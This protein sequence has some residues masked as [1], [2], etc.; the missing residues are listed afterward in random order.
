MNGSG[1]PFAKGQREQ[2]AATFKRRSHSTRR[3]QGTVL[4]VCR[5]KNESSLQRTK[6]MQSSPRFVSNV[7][8]SR[9]DVL[10]LVASALQFF[11]PGSRSFPI[12]RPATVSV[13]TILPRSAEEMETLVSSQLRR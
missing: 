2:A 5:R 7:L 4:R 12:R 9:D 6:A 1:T 13:R 3:R 11:Q 8:S 10:S